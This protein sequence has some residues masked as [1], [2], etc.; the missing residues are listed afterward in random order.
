M[1]PVHLLRRTTR[2]GL[3]LKRAANRCRSPGWCGHIVRPP[4]RLHAYRAHGNR[5]LNRPRPFANGM[6]A[7]LARPTRGSRPLGTSVGEGPHER[8]HLGTGL[9]WMD[10]NGLL[11]P[12]TGRTPMGRIRGTH[13]LLRARLLGRP[14]PRPTRRPRPQ[15]VPPIAG[16][17]APQLRTQPASSASITRLRSTFD[18]A[19]R[20][21]PGRP[22]S[23][24]VG[25][26]TR[27]PFGLVHLT[28]AR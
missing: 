3:L 13:P 24:S 22:V 25:T 14:R 7:R 26:A 20:S 27:P 21:H 11:R 10:R 18:V 28:Q 4:R 19:N 23:P 15:L 5:E 1:V 12:R 2:L 6:A 9:V 17:R 8:R 16:N